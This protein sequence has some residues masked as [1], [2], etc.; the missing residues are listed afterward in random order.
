MTRVL[1][2][3]FI[4]WFISCVGP[5]SN[6][7]VSSQSAFEL[8]TP[9]SFGAKGDGKADDYMAFQKAIDYCI[10]YKRK[11]FIPSGTYRITKTLVLKEGLVIEGES[12]I[13]SYLWFDPVSD[14]SLIK[15]DAGKKGHNLNISNLKLG[16]RSFGKDKSNVHA[17]S[18]AN[19]R[20]RG[21]NISNTEFFGFSGYGI[22]L[23]GNDTYGQNLAFRDLSFYRMGGMVGQSND[24]GATEWW[25]NIVIFENINLDAYSGHTINLQ[26]PQKY[27][28]DMRGWRMVNITNLLIEG[29]I[30]PG[31]NIQ[32]SV[33]LGGGE[34]NKKNKMIG[35]GN[36]II[37]GYWEEFSS[38]IRPKYSFEINEGLF[39]VD[40]KD[41]KVK[42]FQVN[43][44]SL[45]LNIDGMRIHGLNTK[46]RFEINGKAKIVL[47][48]VYNSKGGV[49]DASKRSSSNIEIQS[50]ISNQK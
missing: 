34:N 30:K 48:N 28:F 46:D 49:V 33:R 37:E 12:R 22:Y 16:L 13:G 15:L 7:Q 20:F 27:I 19:S 4:L 25:T 39:L 45:C 1:Y 8:T 36:V 6:N 3:S 21:M 24:R 41:L 47:N 40:I 9:S 5:K 31:A 14:K 42:N 10:E 32:A 18:I 43:A 38:K 26:S 44:N 23:T 29:S 50:V 17:I 35:R 2:F 11:L